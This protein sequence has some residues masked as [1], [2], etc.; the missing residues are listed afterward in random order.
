MAN[1]SADQ[2]FVRGKMGVL[3]TDGVTLVPI[4]IDEASGGMCVNTTDTISF[5]MQPI[6]ERDENFN[7][8]LLWVGTDG[9]TYPWV[10]NASGEVLIQE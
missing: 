10:C 5:T 1:A 6:S 2:N 9:L 3:N 8:C 7:K 4:K